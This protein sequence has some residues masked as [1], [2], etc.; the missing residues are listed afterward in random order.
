MCVAATPTA[1]N[2]GSQQALIYGPAYNTVAQQSALGT[3]E[4][5]Y[6]FCLLS[7]FLRSSSKNT[8]MD[9]PWR[10]SMNFT[11]QAAIKIILYEFEAKQ[12]S[13]SYYFR[14]L[15]PYNL[16]VQLRFPEQF[17]QTL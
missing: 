13:C 17:T 4:S 11:R 8:N 1:C 10:N 16:F 15:L 9:D 12:V 6:N 7:Y 2:S 14:K 3:D 5:Q